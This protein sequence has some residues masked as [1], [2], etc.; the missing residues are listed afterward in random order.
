MS[1][2]K[3]GLWLYYW[4]ILAPDEPEPI[5]EYHFDKSIGCNHRF[6]WTY[7]K[8]KIAVEVDGGS[9]APG[10]GRHAT[11]RDRDKLNIAASLG[12][13]VFRFSPDQLQ[14]D[15]TACVEIVKRTLATVAGDGE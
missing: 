11:D 10:G 6:D 7:K 13:R 15:P 1:A 8:N 3:S 4:H 9:H 12:W 5:P 14:R 2:D